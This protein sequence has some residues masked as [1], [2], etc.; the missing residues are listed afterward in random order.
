VKFYG[1]LSPGISTALD[2]PL[3][4]VLHQPRK[5]SGLVVKIW[6]TA[7]YVDIEGRFV[8]EDGDDDLLIELHGDVEPDPA[9]R[10]RGRGKFVVKNVV[11]PPRDAKAKLQILKLMVEG[12][13][14]VFDAAVP[15]TEAEMI[16]QNF[17]IAITI[18]HGGGEVFK[19]SVPTF[20]R[21]ALASPRVIGRRVLAYKE[22]E[23]EDPE[24]DEDDEVVL[25]GHLV[26]LGTATSETDDGNL[27]VTGFARIDESGRLLPC[28]G[29]GNPRPGELVV[30]RTHKDLFAY[31]TS[32]LPKVAKTVGDSSISLRLCH[33]IEPD[34][35][36]ELAMPHTNHLFAFSTSSGASN[37]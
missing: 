14:T 27:V 9:L 7:S 10:K 12:D 4:L 25:A 26:T 18:E 33:P 28:D 13:P 29:E 32:D 17:E 30:M 8:K 22:G 15:S 2:T 19:S 37:E 3:E 11:H 5:A 20:I 23:D 24:W 34:G 1:R 36:I 6:E 35:T 21:P 16:G 31:I